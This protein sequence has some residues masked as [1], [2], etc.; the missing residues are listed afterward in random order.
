MCLCMKKNVK[1][2]PMMMVLGYDVKLIH[3]VLSITLNSRHEGHVCIFGR[4]AETV[5]GLKAPAG[6][7]VFVK[8]TWLALLCLYYIL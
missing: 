5:S 8:P 1:M 7:G 4:V 2:M 3:C 6:K